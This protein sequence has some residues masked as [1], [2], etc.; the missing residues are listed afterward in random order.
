MA[1]SKE[2][3]NTRL[4]KTY[5]WSCDQLSAAEKQRIDAQCEKLKNARNPMLPYDKMTGF[6]IKGWV[7]KCKISNPDK[8][9]AKDTGR[10]F[11]PAEIRLGIDSA[12][13]KITA[14]TIYSMVKSWQL[15]TGKKIEGGLTE[16]F[17]NKLPFDVRDRV[18]QDTKEVTGVWVNCSIPVTVSVQ[19]PQ[20]DWQIVRFASEVDGKKPALQNADTVLG[21]AEDGKPG[22]YVEVSINAHL[23]ADNQVFTRAAQITMKPAP[24]RETNYDIADLLD[25]SAEDG[26]SV[27]APSK[28]EAVTPEELAGMIQ[29]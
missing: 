10:V 6:G 17:G 5:D 16:A 29:I 20:N 23:T 7:N 2:E 25:P 26:A 4:Q 19:N 15:K 21:P 22:A 18:N 28:P 11:Y 1:L 3:L 27:E 14:L 9:V 24:S 12:S 13:Y 8:M